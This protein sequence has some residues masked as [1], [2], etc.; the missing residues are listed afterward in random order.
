MNYKYP[1]MKNIITQSDKNAMIAFI[2]KTDRFTNGQ[3][4]KKFE[5]EW[6]DW[7][8]SKYS[9]FVSS[10]SAANFLLVAAVKELYGL[11]DGD[12]VIVPAC[13][14]MT[15]VAPIIQLGLNPIFVDIEMDTYGF[16]VDSLLKVENPESI[17]LVFISHLLGLRCPVERYKEIFP[18]A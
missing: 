5:N 6:N 3:M 12:N 7:L 1:L 18:N 15:N 11:K 8:G 13:T 2:Q 17:K 9:L 14:W 10:G 16:N 4:V